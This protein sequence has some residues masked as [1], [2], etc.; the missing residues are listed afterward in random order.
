M[1]DQALMISFQFGMI[2]QLPTEG[3]GCQ[4]Y[5]EVHGPV[6]AAVGVVVDTA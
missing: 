5:L 1:A 6:I 2:P 3:Y 4:V